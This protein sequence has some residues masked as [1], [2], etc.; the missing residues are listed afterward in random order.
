MSL[1]LSLYASKNSNEGMVGWNG[2]E[3]RAGSISGRREVVGPQTGIQ[4]QSQ[5]GL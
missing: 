4:D 5:H 2:A 1:V 3:H